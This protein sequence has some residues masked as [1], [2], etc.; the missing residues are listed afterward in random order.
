MDEEIEKQL[1]KETKMVQVLVD[2]L[3]NYE[4]Q[5]KNDYGFPNK[6]KIS[7]KVKELKKC[8]QLMQSV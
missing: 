5:L 1:L 4:R 2:R 8:I 7:H 6:Q 3:N